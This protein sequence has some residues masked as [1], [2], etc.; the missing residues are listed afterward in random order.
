M[1]EVRLYIGTSEGNIAAYPISLSHATMVTTLLQD[2]NT[3]RIRAHRLVPA[4][5]EDEIR[6]RDRD[7]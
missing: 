2:V 5:V 4:S 3:E 7:T 6:D 1:L